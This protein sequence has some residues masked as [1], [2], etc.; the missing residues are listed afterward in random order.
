VSTR[1]GVV[2]IAHGRHAHLA[3]Q[4]WGLAR[5]VQQPDIFVA[6]AMDDPGIADVVA[7][8]AQPGWDVTVASV[9]STPAGLP[10][11]AARNAGARAAIEA[12]AQ[13]LVFLDVDCIPSP[14]LLQRYAAVLDEATGSRSRVSRN[15]PVVASG[16][17]G[18]LPP[19]P[20]PRDYRDQDLDA[21]ARPHPARPA[22]RADE[23]RVAEDLRLFWSLSFA[24]DAGDWDVLGGFCEDYVGYGG[25]DTDFGQRLGATEGTLLWVGGA[26][27]YHQHHPSESPPV[28]HLDAIVGNANRF[29][30]MWGWFPMEGWLEH[31]AAMGLAELERDTGQW[32]VLRPG[33]AR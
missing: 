30:D 9:A 16:E 6:V 23:V 1:T 7:A 18:Y 12:G 20:D 31:F 28:R 8:H 15:G 14:T 11:A 24:I 22:L 17:V 19:V 33:A 29:H 5:Q 32:R 4:L 21:L 25:E 27:A 13:T 26:T 3:G 10:L 2:T